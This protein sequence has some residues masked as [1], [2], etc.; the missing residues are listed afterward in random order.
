MK[1]SIIVICIM[2]VLG[3]FLIDD[4][5]CLH[6]K[7]INQ[8]DLKQCQKLM[9]VAH[10]DDETIW[11]GSHL[12]KGHYLVVCL[13]NG[14]NEK[15][16]K[17]FMS[18]MKETH[19]QGLMFDY[20]DKTNGQRDKWLHVKQKIKKDITYILNKKAWAMVVTHNPLGEYG[21]IH[22][23]LTSQIVSIEATNQNLYYF[24]KYYKKKHVPHAL[25]K[26]DQKNYDEK[27]Q[28]IQ[29]YASQ[30]KVM[31]HLDHMM[32]HENWVKAKDWRSL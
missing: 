32:N 18:I 13:T 21:H 1:K 28:L 4:S 10:P 14:N 6:Q 9:I 15:R 19:N 22:H 31:E 16:K 17:E 20:P 23:R 24:G 5:K 27:M 25:K 8:I 11:G 29:K 2:V 3:C 12:L 26:I 30:K 7:E